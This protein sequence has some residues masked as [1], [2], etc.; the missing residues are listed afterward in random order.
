MGRSICLIP[1]AWLRIQRVFTS[2][3]VNAKKSHQGTNLAAMLAPESNFKENYSKML[4]SI[5]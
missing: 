3:I 5:F 1:L 4:L 2:P